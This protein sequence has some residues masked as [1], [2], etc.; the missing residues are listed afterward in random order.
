MIPGVSSATLTLP[1]Y[2]RVA[3]HPTRTRLANPGLE[4]K[5]LITTASLYI[6]SRVKV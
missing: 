2:G 6:L 3:R 4:S 5:R 1:D